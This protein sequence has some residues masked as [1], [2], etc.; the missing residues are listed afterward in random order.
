MNEQEIEKITQSTNVI[1]EWSV[2][3]L[4]NMGFAEKW[5]N[6]INL[7]FLLLVLVVT[8]FILCLRPLA[9]EGPV[10]IELD[11][12]GLSVMMATLSNA[13]ISILIGMVREFQN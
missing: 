2:Q 12:I 9:A 7:V 6:Y 13:T 8:A 5:I 4:R 10:A 1:S 11:G 3:L